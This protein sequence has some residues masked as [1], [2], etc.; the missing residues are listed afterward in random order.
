LRIND[1]TF[2]ARWP[3]FDALVERLADAVES[4]K[5]L[6]AADWTRVLLLTDLT[7]TSTLVGAGH[8]ALTLPGRC[9]ESFAAAPRADWP[10]RTVPGIYLCVI[11][12]PATIPGDGGSFPVSRQRRRH[13][14]S[15]ESS[16][17]RGIFCV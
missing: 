7:G 13:R 1:L 16:G 11:S 12:T 3:Q 6:P 14:I 9:R 5:T 10:Q 8:E 17:H 4:R 15:G 2:A